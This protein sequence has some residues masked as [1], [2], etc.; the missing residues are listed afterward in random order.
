MGVRGIGLLEGTLGLWT[1]AVPL[2][3]DIHIAQ[4]P[5]FPYRLG[6]L[7]WH[8][9]QALFPPWI[10][11]VNTWSQSVHTL[12]I[13]ISPSAAMPQVRT[14]PPNGVPRMSHTRQGAWDLMGN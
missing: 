14:Y 9:W 11:G 2:H 13:G 4:E 7:K 1:S 5:T 8:L 10:C 3:G 12:L 6:W